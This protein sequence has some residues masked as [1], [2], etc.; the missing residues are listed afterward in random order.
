MG[1]L[2]EEIERS[3]V[4][5]RPC[6]FV[7]IN[8]DGFKEYEEKNGKA[9]AEVAL[10]KVAEFLRGCAGPLGKVGRRKDDTFGIVMP[11]ANKKGSLAAAEKIR[12]GVE[13]LALSEEKGDRLT[14]SCGVSEN[15]L[16]G[17][18]SDEIFEKANA[19]LN[20][21]KKSG[22]NKVIGAGV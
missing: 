11:E 14:V 9:Q 8:I 20:R 16:D 5:Q 21:A 17:A 1:R 13:K 19:A 7:L 18:S 12:K 22:R 4:S 6:S 15:P 2:K 10:R 3:V